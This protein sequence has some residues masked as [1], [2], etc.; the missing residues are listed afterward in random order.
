M[1]KSL[2]SIILLVLSPMACFCRT[3][4]LHFPG[5]ESRFADRSSYCVLTPEHTPESVERMVLEFEYMP[6][7]V[8]SPGYILF[9]KNARGDEAF[10]LTYSFDR[11]ASTISFAKDGKQILAASSFQADE[12]PH[13]LPVAITLDAAA[14]SVVVKIGNDRFGASAGMDGSRFSPQIHFGMCGHILETASFSIGSLSLSLDRQRIGFPLDESCGNDVHSSDGRVMGAVSN[15]IW[16]INRSYYWDEVF[17]AEF[18]TPAGV[19]FA[20]TSGEFMIY[21]R[22]S[23]TTFTLRDHVVSNRSIS[24]VDK[25]WYTR[26]G[27][28]FHNPASNHIISYELDSDRTFVGDINPESTACTVVEQGSANLQMH[29]HCAAYLPDSAKIVL[30]G[31]Y[32]NRRYYNDFI[33]FDVATSR[34]DTIPFTGDVI[35]PRFFASMCVSPDGNSLYIYGGKGNAVGNQD[36]GVEYYYDLYEANLRSRTIRKLWEQTPPE[37][38][39]VPTRRMIASPD[40]RYLYMMAYPEYHPRSVLRLYRMSIADGSCEELADSIPIVSEEIATNAALYCSRELDRLYC[41]VQEFQ[42]VSDAETGGANTVRIYSLDAPPVSLAAVRRYEQSE[43]P[44]SGILWWLLAAL[45]LFVVTAC[46][47]W[48]RY[49]RRGRD[50]MPQ[51]ESVAEPDEDAACDVSAG[52]LLAPQRNSLMLFGLFTARDRSGHDVSHM[53][54][55]KN[56]QLFV[57]LLINS[58]GKN[59]VLSSDLNSLFWP[60]KPDENIKNLKNVTINKLRKVLQ[61]FDGIELVHN[62]GFFKV[63]MSEGFYCDYERLHALTGGFSLSPDGDSVP[64]ELLAVISRGKFLTGMEQPVFDYARQRVENYSIAMLSA[65]ISICFRTGDNAATLAAC[66]ALA[67]IDSLSELAMGHAVKVYMRM[68]R[69]AKAQSVFNTFVRDY[70]KAM[71]EDFSMTFAAVAGNADGH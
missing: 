15:P 53:F 52:E 61:E 49:R 2:L 6:N 14:D 22:D 4:G 66:N 32:G 13:R 59:G 55:P 62:K 7:N 16:L 50:C 11:G 37:S 1:E 63:E 41:V 5:N 12:L 17:S 21:S 27:M 8:K 29:H 71:G 33:T 56:R 60:D 42:V 18:S 51:S 24:N 58:I 20:E 54:S 70:R 34:W 9:I 67:A 30:F 43:N 65:R 64:A 28:G 48:M 38:N 69:E 31:G 25:G 68:N 10:N 35:S 47:L 3:G 57:Y 44:S 40:G 45:L 39:R 46:W 19:V 26:L 23:L 36:V